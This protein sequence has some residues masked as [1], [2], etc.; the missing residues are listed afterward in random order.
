V[1]DLQVG[2]FFFS[3]LATRLPAEAG[4]FPIPAAPPF[5]SAGFQPALS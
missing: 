1:A 4:Y 3:F 5:R 2:F